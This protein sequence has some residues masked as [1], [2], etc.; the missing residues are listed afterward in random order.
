M[1]REEKRKAQKENTTKKG[2]GKLSKYFW[3]IVKK[4]RSKKN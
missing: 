2:M 4:R 1:N 3:K